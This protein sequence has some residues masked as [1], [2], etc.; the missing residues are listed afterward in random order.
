MFNPYYGCA[1]HEVITSN[2]D[3][4]PESHFGFR[5]YRPEHPFETERKCEAK[6]RLEK[7]LEKRREDRC[8]AQYETPARELAAPS[9]PPLPPKI[10]VEEAR[11][12]DA[13]ILVALGCKVP[14]NFH[15]WFSRI[16]GR[17]NRVLSRAEL[18]LD[19]KPVRV[20]SNPDYFALHQFD[21]TGFRV[22][23]CA[24]ALSQFII[25]SGSCLLQGKRVAEIGCGMGVP[26]I[27]AAKMGARKVMSTDAD[28]RAVETVRVNAALNLL[29]D[30]DKLTAETLRFGQFDRVEE[31]RRG[32]PFDL[33]MAVDIF[34]NWER[35]M[36]RDI[37]RT[38]VA[39]VADTDSTEGRMVALI[40]YQERPCCTFTVFNELIKELSMHGL[41]HRYESIPAPYGTVHNMHLI[42]IHA[43]PGLG[44]SIKPAYSDADLVTLENNTDSSDDQDE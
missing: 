1:V 7:R 26:S 13:E 43:P 5:K 18:V 21:S 38:I 40:G 35:Q 9:S 44:V 23:D 12:A 34:Y 3:L 24:V 29:E 8:K 27:V 37:A 36:M 4:D 42:S 30:F 15:R 25:C 16:A 41:M 19:G 17:T 32:E 11:K 31:L 28:L 14:K 20:V 10:T 22:W 2:V 39:L 33:V 6:A